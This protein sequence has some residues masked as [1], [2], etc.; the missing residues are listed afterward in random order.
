LWGQEVPGTWGVEGWVALCSGVTL[1]CPQGGTG[2]A[3]SRTSAPAPRVA[4]RQPLPATGH[5]GVISQT[6]DFSIKLRTQEEPSGF[7]LHWS[8]ASGEGSGTRGVCTCPNS[9]SAKA[10]EPKFNAPAGLH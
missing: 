6:L 9:I 3:E 7:A 8:R 10:D 4:S 1:S 2:L 5:P